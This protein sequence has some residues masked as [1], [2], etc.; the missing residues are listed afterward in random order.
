MPATKH[1]TVNRVR[2]LDYKAPA[3]EKGIDIIELLAGEQNGLTIS[4]IAF[5]LKRSLSEIFRVAVVMERR[6]WLQKDPESSRYTVTYRLLELAHRGTPAQAMSLVAAP[7]MSQLSHDINQSCHLVVPAGGHGLVI[8]R[9]ENAAT[10]GG[11]SMRVGAVVDLIATSPGH[12]L[13]A[14]AEPD[15]RASILRLIPAPWPLGR[16]V[17]ERRLARVRSRGCEIL[18]SALAAG[19]T[20][21]SYPIH[22]REGRVVAA[23]TVPFLAGSRRAQKLT[24]DKTRAMLQRAARQVSQSLVLIR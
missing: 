8:L 4:E 17:L 1:T 16:K 2:R 9:Q 15:V 10:P 18:P 23:L 7:V 3:L 19:V 11:F 13:L 21:I 14:F 24:L 12:L 22:A 6:Q 5:R 20:D